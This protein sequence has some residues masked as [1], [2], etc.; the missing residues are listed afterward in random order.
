[1]TSTDS[2]DGPQRTITR[3]QLLQRAGVS[4]GGLLVAPSLLAACG[5][6]AGSGPAPGGAG[7]GKAALNPLRLAIAQPTPVLDLATS[8]TRSTEITATLAGEPLLAYDST[9]KMVPRLAQSFTVESPTRFVIGLRSGVK[10][11]DGSPVTAEDVVASLQRHV[12]PS[13]SASQLAPNFASYASVRARGS[14][15]VVVTLKQPDPLAPAALILALVM[16]AAFIR[17]HEGKIGTPTT[18]PPGTGPFKVTQFQPGAKAVLEP[19]AHWRGA[20]PAAKRITFAYL[21]D[22]QAMRLGA[23]S[24]AFDVA[25]SL[26][27]TQSEAWKAISGFEVRSAP[28]VESLM[29]SF[30]MGKAPWSDP[31]VRRAVTHCWNGP[32]VVAGVLGSSAQAAT[33]IVPPALWSQLVSDPAQV[34]EIYAGLQQYPFSIDQAKQEIAKSSVPR[35]FEATIAYPS[36]AAEAGNAL[37]NF[38]KNLEAI[39]VKLTLRQ[40]STD[41]WLQR[42]LGDKDKLGIEILSLTPVTADPMKLLNLVVPSAAATPNGFNLANYK[43]SAVDALIARQ[44]TAQ[45]AERTALITQIVNQLSTDLPYLPLWWPQTL[46]AIGSNVSFPGFTAFSNGWDVANRIVARRA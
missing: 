1:M 40:V 16:P 36:V 33:S 31:H 27:P 35:G 9:L 41:A 45:Q 24:S 29:L 34:E 17:R 38:A 4:V 21:Q 19:N 7:G 8:T 26:S 14:D 28:G 39:G 18:L 44:R 23:Q 37:Q 20:R 6:S 11:S 32:G 22:E 10:F 2:F 5:S 43:S 42:V 12:D 3:A 25:F 15:A 46:M 30:N 13:K